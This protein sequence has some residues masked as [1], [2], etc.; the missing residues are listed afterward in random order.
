[1]AGRVYRGLGSGI[2][3]VR[4][5]FG[6]GERE[7]F[8]EAEVKNF[9]MPARSDKNIGWLDVAMNDAFGVS[10]VQGVG[11]FDGQ[12]QKRFSIEW[13]TGNFVL[14]GGPLKALHGNKSAAL[15]FADVINRADIGMIQ[16][17]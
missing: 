12:G 9:G 10:G 17:G 4:R 16:R 2:E 15:V 1:M 13:R 14:E 8:G 7:N 6:C 11:D 5:A 3:G